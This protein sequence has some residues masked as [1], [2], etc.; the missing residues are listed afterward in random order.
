[1][2]IIILGKEGQNISSA[3]RQHL[4]FQSIYK[5]HPSVSFQRKLKWKRRGLMR[6]TSFFFTSEVDQTKLLIDGRMFSPLLGPVEPGGIVS[7]SRAFWK[8][9]ERRQDQRFSWREPQTELLLRC[10][11]L[12]SITVAGIL[13]VLSNS[14]TAFAT[15]WTAWHCS[16]RTHI[17]TH[18]NLTC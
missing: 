9:C 18:L 17:H 6:E 11:Y 3:P 2:V 5:S 1:M 7:R 15:S 16:T 14:D 8:Y 10:E 4:L 13:P 12:A